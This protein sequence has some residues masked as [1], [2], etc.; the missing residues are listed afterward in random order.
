MQETRITSGGIKNALSEF[1]IE[2]AISEYVSNGFD[3]GASKIDINISYD[4]FE[5]VEEMTISDNG[6]GIN[7]DLLA[8]KFLHFLESEKSFKQKEENIGL[9]GKNGYGRYTYFKFAK[10]VEWDTSYEKSKKIFNY[11]IKSSSENLES[12]D[13]SKPK[14][15]T[16]KTSKT[17]TTVKFKE[18]DK[19][20]SRQYV[21]TVLTSHLK[22][23]FAWLLEL[24]KS[25]GFKIS[26]NKIPLNYEDIILDN[27]DFPVV[28]KDSEGK[29]LNSFACKFIQWNRKLV[30]EY[31]KFY[32][33]NEK[34][35]LKQLRTT[36]LNNKGDQ[37][38]HSVI[39][40]SD[41]FE[42]FIYREEETEDRIKLKLFDTQNE[43]KIYTTLIGELNLFLRKKRKPFLHKYA[44][45]LIQTYEE[46]KVMPKFGN[47]S[48]DL[49]RKQEFHTLVKELYEVEPGLFV[50][51]NTEQKKTFLQLLNLI[52][53]SDER[54]TFFNII[55]EVVQLEPQ[56][57]KDLEKILKTTKLN[58]IIKAMRLVQDRMVVINKFKQLV[59]DHKLKANEKDDLQQ[60]IEQH[61]WVF[62][63]EYNFVC[64]AEVKFDEALRK[65][66]YILK[67]TEEYKQV[68]HKNKLKEVDLFV[69]GQELRDGKINNL[70]VEIKNPT[71]IKTLKS[72]H[73]NQLKLYKDTI[74]GIDEFNAHSNVDWK[75]YLI[76]QEY[77][78]EI[79][80]E[81][82]N[83]Q[84]HGIRNCVMKSRN[85]T[86]FVFKWSEILNDIEIRL[87]WLNEKL[88][89]EK[90]KLYKINGSIN[91][92][93]SDID[94]STAIQ[95]PTSI[96]PAKR[97]KKNMAGIK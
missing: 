89:V 73:L 28:I 83:A 60:L 17:G 79:A 59:F 44:D 50:K 9:L 48:W 21:D 37:F 86:M 8:Q 88:K 36:K 47:E 23:E 63:E 85:F 74:M 87:N 13:P 67:A 26:I 78:S 3:A 56:E 46:E 5:S 27:E 16:S 51:L 54:E 97:R 61:Y 75:F 12:F 94:N 53:E 7:Y 45:T 35:K 1:N 30:D 11:L 33:V 2:K 55:N 18:I 25:K 58:N 22:G 65:Y 82:T 80:D 42:N 71:L 20:V 14:D 29:V 31:S 93:F 77:N 57:R 39:V 43:Q 15:V 38:Y 76:G 40:K 4:K 19:K 34:G 66:L 95:N 69:S 81:M 84:N 32:F 62:G 92:L 6:K 52:L 70:I 68:T 49:I 91:E 10:F 41:F 64:A 90:E 72:T 96:L 24:N